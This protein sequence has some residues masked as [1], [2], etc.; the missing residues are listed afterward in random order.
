MIDTLNLSFQI[1]GLTET[2][3]NDNNTDCFA[4]NDY[5]YYCS[6]RSTKKG[7]GLGLYVNII[8]RVIYRPPSGNSDSFKQAVN[9]ILETVDRENILFY[10]MGDFNIDLFKSESCNY[11][12][13]FTEQLFTLFFFPLITKATRIT[14][15]T[16]TLIDH[17]F[18]NNQEQPLMTVS[19]AVYFQRYFRLLANSACV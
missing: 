3:L 12:S 19:T 18:T 13:S 14:H 8:A 9:E 6:N 10:M 2:W 7:G 5:E 15:H 1:I 17:I 4:L 11:A 16:A